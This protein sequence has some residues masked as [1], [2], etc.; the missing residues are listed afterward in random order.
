MKFLIRSIIPILIIQLAGCA[1]LE[2]V[3]INEIDVGKVVSIAKKT[4]DAIRPMTEEEEYYLGRAVAAMILSKYPIY[5]NDPL[6]HYINL[7]GQTVVISS[8]RPYTYGGYHFAVLDT[9]EVNAF[10]C[11]GGIIFI[12]TG[13]LRE[14]NNEEELAAVLAHEAAHVGLRHGVSAIKASRWAEIVVAIGAEA[15]R[16]Y[17]RSEISNLV[18]LFEGSIEDVFKTIVVN[19][20]SKDQ[21]MSADEGGLLYAN[22]AGY[23][24]KGLTSFLHRLMASDKASKGGMFKTHPGANDRLNKI[25]KIIE[26][27]G[28]KGSEDNIRINRFRA[29]VPL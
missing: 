14:I 11:P 21:E 5:N 8:E 10:A 18:G 25:K 26:E 3:S 4:G 13:M 17:T 15:A 6:Q 9:E 27:K 20:Y 16:N 12:T 29:N 28:L 23:D 1:V 2:R 7:V 24:P 22:R 19:G